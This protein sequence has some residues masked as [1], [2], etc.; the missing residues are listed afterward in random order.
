MHIP[1]WQLRLSNTSFNFPPLV[2]KMDTLHYLPLS[3][4]MEALRNDDDVLNLAQY[5]NDHK[6]IRVYTEHGMTNLLT[7]FMDPKPIRIVIIEQLQEIEEH[8]TPPPPTDNQPSGMPQTCIP[9][10]IVNE[11]T[12]ALLIST[13]YNKKMDFIKDKPLS[14]CIKKLAM[15]D[16]CVVRIVN[17]QN[18]YDEVHEDEDDAVNEVHEGEDNAVNMEVTKEFNEMNGLNEF[19]E[20]HE[21]SDK[22]VEMRDFAFDD[23][24]ID[25]IETDEENH[26]RSDESEDSDDSEFWVNE[27]NIIPNVEVDMRVTKHRDNEGSEEDIE[28]L[29]VI[30]NDQ[31][32]SLDE[33]SDIKRNMRVVL[34]E[35][36]KEKR[37]SQGEIHRVTFRIGQKYKSKKELKEK[38]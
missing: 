36:G 3:Y 31:W 25:K 16:V 28:E 21:I 8:E 15:D 13:E 9:P 5:V 29:D 2:L 12:L 30:D 33:G 7:Y 4:I 14:S 35:L 10:I 1:M 37:C 17:E 22:N 32:D 11:A 19:N 38:I 6:L 34:K 20:M 24:I 18:V 26:E 27:D 23:G